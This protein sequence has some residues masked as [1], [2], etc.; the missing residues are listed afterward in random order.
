MDREIEKRLKGEY[1]GKVERRGQKK[2]EEIKRRKKK[3]E[4][5]SERP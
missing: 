3:E 5:G 1:G 2:E 4:I